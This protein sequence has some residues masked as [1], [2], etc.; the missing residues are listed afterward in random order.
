MHISFVKRKTKISMKCKRPLSFL[1]TSSCISPVEALGHLLSC[2]MLWRRK[3]KNCH[4]LF[5]PKDRG[6]PILILFLSYFFPFDFLYIFDI[7]ESHCIFQYCILFFFHL[8]FLKQ[9]F[10]FYHSSKELCIH[11]FLLADWHSLLQIV[12]G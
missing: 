3:N 8:I 2:R 12:H 1:E 4:M 10:F 5:V 6:L 11:H 9:F 7:V